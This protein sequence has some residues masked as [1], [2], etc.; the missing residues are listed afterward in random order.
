MPVNVGGYLRRRIH[1]I[2]REFKPLWKNYLY[3]SF[4]ATIVVFIILLL[5]NMEH[6]VVIASIGASACVQD[7]RSPGHVFGE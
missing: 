7:P 2:C 4:L 3:Q 6:A 5:L 1:R